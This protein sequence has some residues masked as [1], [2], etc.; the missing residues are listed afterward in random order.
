MKNIAIVY[1]VFICSFCFLLSSCDP[2]V[3][4]KMI[5][6]NN[7]D[8]DIR[9]FSHTNKFDTI[10]HVPIYDTL[11]VNKHSEVLLSEKTDYGRLKSNS[12]CQIEHLFAK[13]EIVQDT[14]LHL[15]LNLYDNASWVSKVTK[16]RMS[17]S[18]TCEAKLYITNQH[19]Q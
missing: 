7:S 13:S 4:H 15:N 6:I 12:S 3:S 5:V 19:I 17:G 16:K 14:S 1:R 11:V 8:Y 9:F 2:V 10:N 18:G